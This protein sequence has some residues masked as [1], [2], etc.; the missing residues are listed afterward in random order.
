MLLC[1]LLVWRERSRLLASITASL[2]CTNR[3]IRSV[4]MRMMR[5]N[6]IQ[7]KM[8][9]KTKKV[10]KTKRFPCVARYIYFD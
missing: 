7:L 6:L 2:E 9:R 1:V 5:K 3:S 10:S 8:M 4:M